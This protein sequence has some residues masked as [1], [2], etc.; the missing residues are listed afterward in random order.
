[1]ETFNEHSYLV[2]ASRDCPH[3]IQLRL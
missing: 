3:D 1:M 2:S